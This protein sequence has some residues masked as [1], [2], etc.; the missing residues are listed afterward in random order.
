MLLISL[1]YP[2][3]WISAFW[4]IIQPNLTVKVDVQRGLYQICDEAARW[5]FR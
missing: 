3:F 4:T 1:V 5:C 2:S